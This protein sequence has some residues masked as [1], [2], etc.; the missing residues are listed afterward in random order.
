MFGQSRRVAWLAEAHRHAGHADEAV[1]L[2]RRAV[3]LAITHRERGHEAWA[4]HTLAQ[5][6]PAADHY[7]RAMTLAEELEMRPLVA[8]CHLGLG[9]LQGPPEHLTAA[10]EL[11]LFGRA[12]LCLGYPD[13]PENFRH[14]R[15]VD[16]ILS[17]EW[18]AAPDENVDFWLAQQAA[19]LEL[20]PQGLYFT[21]LFREMEVIVQPDWTA[22]RVRLNLPLSRLAIYRPATVD[23]VLTKM[24]RGDDK[25]LDDIRFLLSREPMALEQLQVA[26]DR[27]RV[28]D[29][30]EIRALFLA[31]QPK[32]LEIARSILPKT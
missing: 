30:L 22:R 24:A 1:V 2:V 3:D 5:A 19:N 21:H 32:V 13:S 27:A 28:P 6:E 8:H 7:R 10:A 4:W 11:T 20:H 18:L 29:V 15:D 23:L 25:D 16:G 12:A 26:F 9:R 17:L 31:A 14:T